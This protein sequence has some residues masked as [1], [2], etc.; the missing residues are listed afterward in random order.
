MFLRKW[1]IVFLFYIPCSYGQLNEPAESGF[2]NFM[3]SIHGHAPEKSSPPKAHYSNPFL[4]DIPVDFEYVDDSTF[5][6]SFY[7][8]GPSSVYF[9]YENQYIHAVLLPNKTAVMHVD[10]L[11]SGN[12]SFSYTSPFQKIFNASEIFAL[13]IGEAFKQNI[14][15]DSDGSMFESSHVYRNTIEENIANAAQKLTEGLEDRETKQYVRKNMEGVFKE[16]FLLSEGYTQRVFQFNKGLGLDSIESLR[17]IP[18]LT[19][20]YFSPI[21]ES[22][23]DP[24]LLGVSSYQKLLS[25]FIID[26]AINLPRVEKVGI[27]PFLDSLSGHTIGWKVFPS[28]C[29][30]ELMVA[31]GF[32]NFINGGRRGLWLV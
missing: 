16:L 11:S 20:E 14:M 24:G 9:I 10:Y 6:L 2:A 17:K 5:L 4:F 18:P 8:H 13:K 31:K 15:P 28:D 12:F 25:E 29:F 1:L 26:T 22:A 21:L 3:I 30:L 23:S 7:T 32:S 27:P 19:K